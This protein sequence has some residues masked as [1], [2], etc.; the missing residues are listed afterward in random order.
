MTLQRFDEGNVID[1]LARQKLLYPFQPH[2]HKFLQGMVYIR[3]AAIANRLDKIDPNWEFLIAREVEN[4]NGV[5]AIGQLR[6]RGIIR[7]NAGSGTIQTVTS[8]GEV[9]PNQLAENVGNA[10]KAAATDAF[11]RTARLF[12]V[13]RYLLG[14]PPEAQFA[15]WIDQQLKEAAQ[16]YAN[17]QAQV[18]AI[19]EV[20]NDDE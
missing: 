7:A 10:Y 12:G 2:E 3:E 4:R 18:G 6:L 13:G 17:V 5:I 19:S 11:K 15:K 14:A 1:D 8:K 16:R 9:S 20:L